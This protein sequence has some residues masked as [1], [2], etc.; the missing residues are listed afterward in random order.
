MTIVRSFNVLLFLCRQQFSVSLETHFNFQFYNSYISKAHFFGGLS[1]AL[2][3][4]TQIHFPIEPS[5]RILFLLTN[6]L[7]VRYCRYGSSGTRNFICIIYS[8]DA[9][10]FID[11]IYNLRISRRLSEPEMVFSNGERL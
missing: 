4:S 1:I 11:I 6:L 10:A 5:N 3:I 9:C 8:T 2:V 7:A